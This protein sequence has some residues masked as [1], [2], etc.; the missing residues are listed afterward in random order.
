VVDE[1]ALRR[2]IGG[3]EVMRAQ[4]EALI[5]AAKLPSVRLQ[6]IPFLAGGHAA[7]GGSFSILRFPDRDLPDV[8][9]IEQLASALY[10]DKRDDVDQYAV[11]M[12]T[13]CIEAEPP[14]RT[15]D[16]LTGILREFD[17]SGR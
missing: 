2:P 12:E 14:D 1:A 7:A 4:I 13:L 10:L 15:V 17:A 6:I 3:H 11:A 16:I 9:Y 5:D 8:V